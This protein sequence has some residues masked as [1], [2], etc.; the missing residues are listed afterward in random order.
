MPNAVIGWRQTSSDP[1]GTGKPEEEPRFGGTRAPRQ[2]Q[3]RSRRLSYLQNAGRMAGHTNSQPVSCGYRSR[4]DYLVLEKKSA[5]A[6]S[7]R[8]GSSDGRVSK[9]RC[10]IACVLIEAQRGCDVLTPDEVLLVAGNRGPGVGPRAVP[11]LDRP[12]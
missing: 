10:I 2:S 3:S 9:D 12:P 11:K 1:A 8:H 6:G 4:L 5:G 7:T